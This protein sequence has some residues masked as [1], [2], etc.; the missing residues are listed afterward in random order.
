MIE[1]SAKE[2]ADIISAEIIGDD[3]VKVSN[4][5]RIEDAECGDITFF[6]NEKYEQY[7]YTTKASIILLPKD[8]NL[9]ENIKATMLLVDDV[10]SSMSVMLE[11]V[12]DNKSKSIVKGIN[13]KSFIDSTVKLGI[14]C[15]IFPFVYI[16]KNSIIG[17]NCIIYP[18]TYI[19]QNC[20]IG[21]NTVIYSNVSIYSDTSVGNNCII[22]SGAILGSDGF[23]FAP[24][25]D[26]Y[27]KIPQIGNVVI[28]D[29]VEIG[30]NSC[31]DRASLGSTIIKK[32]VKLDNLVQVAHNCSIGSNT[33]IASQAGVAGSSSVGEWCQFGG[34]TGIAGHLKIGD[35]VVTG[36]QTGVLGNVKNDSVIFGS[37]AMDINVAKKSFVVIPKLSEIW[38]NVDRLNKTVSEIK[39]VLKK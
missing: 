33:V 35:R 19:G 20:I 17:N 12:S 28:E 21:D 10:Y 23:G 34:Q 9:K 32:G 13:E 27:K 31:V 14:D 8:F 5:A 11:Y 39:D 29:N 6:A 2:L 22:H 36:G 7:L 38:R 16:D 1:L 15:S 4:F 18:H 30:A 25:L 3:F 24:Q 26:G 37:P